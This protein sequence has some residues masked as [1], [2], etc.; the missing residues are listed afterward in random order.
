VT[1]TLELLVEG[2]P[3]VV[4]ASEQAPA[5]VAA[6][7][8]RGLHPFEVPPTVAPAGAQLRLRLEVTGA[9]ATGLRLLHGGPYDSGLQLTVPAD[10]A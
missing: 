9:H 10:L 2:Q 8:V 5:T 6:S 3:A 1:F 7:P 4:L